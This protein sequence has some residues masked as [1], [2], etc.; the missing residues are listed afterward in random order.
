VNQQRLRAS[1]CCCGGRKKIVR[2]GG[3]FQRLSHAAGRRFASFRI[4]PAEDDH[5]ARRAPALR[6]LRRVAAFSTSAI[7]RRRQQDRTIARAELRWPRS[8]AWPA[9]LR[10][11]S[12]VAGATT[13]RSQSRR[14][15]DVAGNRIALGIEQIRVAALMRQALA[16]SGVRISARRW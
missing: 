9:H 8:S 2:C 11:Q 14:K 5:G 12:A 4:S 6:E 7:H 15:T 1:D 10:H 16:A 13:M 3:D